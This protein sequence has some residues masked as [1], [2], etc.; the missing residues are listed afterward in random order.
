MLQVLPRKLTDLQVKATFTSFTGLVTLFAGGNGFGG[1]HYNKPK[2]LNC[3]KVL[4]P[5]FVINSDTPLRFRMAKNYQD[6]LV[7]MIL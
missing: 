2:S 4:N 1:F 3:G 7:L 5:V 6:K